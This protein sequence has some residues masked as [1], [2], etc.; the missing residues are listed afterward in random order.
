MVCIVGLLSCCSDG[1]EDNAVPL[2]VEQPEFTIYL[3]NRG[4]HTGL[5]IPVNKITKSIIAAMVCFDKA[6]YVDFGWGDEVVY[7]TSNETC[8]MDLRAVAVPSP[9][10][11]RVEFFPDDPLNLLE[12]SD[13]TVAF[14]LAPTQFRNLCVY[15]DQGFTRDVNKQ[16]IKT[17]MTS[18]GNV[19]FF[20]SVYTYC[21]LNTCNTWVA[22]ALESSGLDISSCMVITEKGLYNELKRTGIVLKAREPGF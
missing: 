4:I 18:S 2:Q 14:R 6:E 22:D 10:V 17:S 7:Q 13:Y 16:L 3:M 20:K 8:C 1:K 19:V 15:I 9:S 21:G 11:M 12:W 5:I